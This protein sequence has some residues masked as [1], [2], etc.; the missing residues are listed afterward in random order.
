MKSIK[1]VFALLTLI[2]CTM[3]FNVNTATAQTGNEKG[4]FVIAAHE[5]GVQISLLLPAVQKVREAAGRA[6]AKTLSDAKNLAAQVERVGAN[7]SDTQYKTF[8]RNLQSLCASLDRID[9]M[10][11]ANQ[12]PA[13]CMTECDDAYSGWGGG[14]GWNRFWCK[15]AFLK[16]KVGPK[17]GSVGGD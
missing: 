14:K 6:F 16:I 7:M 15:A 10:P 1:N 3:A 12:G 5:T 9:T 11:T 2:A 17:G 8:Q 4:E 13:G